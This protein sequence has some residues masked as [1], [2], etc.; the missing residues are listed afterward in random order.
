MRGAHLNL[1]GCAEEDRRERRRKLGLPEEQSEEEKAAERARLAESA[2][3]KPSIGLPVKPV[4]LLAQLRDALVRAAS[5]SAARIIE[6][7]CDVM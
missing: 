1:G 7:W 3:A 6:G 4:S 5:L 2:K